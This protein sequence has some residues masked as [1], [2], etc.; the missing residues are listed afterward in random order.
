MSQMSW[1]NT[2]VS[3]RGFMI[4]IAG[5]TFAMAAGEER[6]GNAATEA[7][8]AAGTA[9]NPW[10]CPGRRA[11]RAFPHGSTIHSQ[12]IAHSAN[13]FANKDLK[14]AI[15]CSFTSRRSRRLGNPVLS[16]P[17]PGGRGRHS[18]RGL[19]NASLMIAEHK[20]ASEPYRHQAGPSTR[21]CSTVLFPAGINDS[22]SR[23]LA[24]F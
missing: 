23:L 5:L 3:R 22:P 16:A 19:A 18:T 6:F 11:H 8:E 12:R 21:R 20:R 14:S 10:V 24:R 13:T 7:P 1:P 15:T 4:G 9:F 2:G 17:S